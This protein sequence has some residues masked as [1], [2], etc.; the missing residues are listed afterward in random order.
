MKCKKCGYEMARKLESRKVQITL[1]NGDKEVKT[2]TV[3]KHECP[4]CGNHVVDPLSEARYQATLK[5]TG[6]V[7]I[8][9]GK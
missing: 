3:A 9:D 5:S 8:S 4:S 7:E 2:F 6:G 1:R